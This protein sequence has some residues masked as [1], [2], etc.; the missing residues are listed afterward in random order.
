MNSRGRLFILPACM[1]VLA[2]ASASCAVQPT[3]ALGHRWP[4]PCPSSPLSNC[5]AGHLHPSHPACHLAGPLRLSMRPICPTPRPTRPH[6]APLLD[7]YLHNHTRAPPHP[8][9]HRPGPTPQDVEV[10][11]Q[12]ERDVARTH[13]D[14][15][16]FSGGNLPLCSLRDARGFANAAG[17]GGRVQQA[18]AGRD[19]TA[20]AAAPCP[21]CCRRGR[22]RGDA[23]RAHAPRPLRLC[24]AQPG[25]AL[26][27]GGREPAAAG[28][29]SAVQQAGVGIRPRLLGRCRVHCQ[30][31]LGGGW[32]AQ[33]YLFQPVCPCRRPPAAKFRA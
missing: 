9:R 22:R 7:L 15:H 29:P 2:V 1:P 11:E 8:T 19:R 20:R 32:S 12:I 31:V 28:A 4:A 13:P 30:P 18:G 3:G 23:P 27:A 25:A 6:P 26:R 16:F 33:A 17:G 14:M 21:P 5:R 24:Q 10:Q